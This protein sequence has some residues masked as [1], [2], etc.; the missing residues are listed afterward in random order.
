MSYLFEEGKPVDQE[1]S[2]WYGTIAENVT[3]F[4]VKAFVI[5][6]DFDPDKQIGPCF[7]QARNNIDLPLR[8]NRCIV[9]FD[10]RQQLWILAWWP[11]SS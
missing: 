5:L 2:L 11:F 3:D 10:N 1:I 9:I 7:W 4:D 6:P 8:G